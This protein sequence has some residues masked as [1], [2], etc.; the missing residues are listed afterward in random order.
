L[1]LLTRECEL[2]VLSGSVCE[3]AEA[4]SASDARVGRALQAMQRCPS[5]RW[6]V[7]AL[8]K[9]S[10]MSRAAFARAFR[11]ATGQTPLA[12]LCRERLQRAAEL[13]QT[14]DAKLTELAENAGYATEF[15][16]SRA[17]KRLFGIPP[18]RFRRAAQALHALHVPRSSFRCAA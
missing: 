8:A 6:T 11:T 9:Q 15:A 12:W 17:F 1:L 18:A 4:P 10:G 16:F 3:P 14:S 5:R 13:L 7:A 2:Q